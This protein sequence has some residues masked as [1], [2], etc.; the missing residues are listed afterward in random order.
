MDRRRYY[1]SR[2]KRLAKDKKYYEEHKEKWI[3]KIKKAREKSPEKEKARQTLRNAIAR[4]EIKRMPCEVCGKK[5]THA[6]HSD[7]SKPFDVMWLCINHHYEKH[8]KY[9][10]GE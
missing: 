8:R 5:K 3:E 2:K 4:G 6:H 1:K 10:L 7:Y 9:K